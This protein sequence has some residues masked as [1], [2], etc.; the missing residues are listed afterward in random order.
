MGKSQKNYMS[1]KSKLMAAVAMLLVASFMVV[2]STYA[3]FTLSTAPEVTGIKTSVGANGNLEIALLYDA[4]AATAADL[5]NSLE[6]AAGKITTTTGGL[7]DLAEKNKTWGNLVS[8]MEGENDLYGLNQISLKPTRLNV[9]STDDG[10]SFTLAAAPLV[11]PEYGADG[12]ITNL[13]PNTESGVYNNGNYTS[14]G[15]GVRAIGSISGKAQQEID[16][17]NAMQEFNIAIGQVSS[18]AAKS[19]N[20]NGENLTTLI[21]KYSKGE[22]TL[23]AT[24][25]VNMLNALNGTNNNNKGVVYYMTEAR[26]AL[27]KAAYAYLNETAA[28]DEYISVTSVEIDE[29]DTITLKNGSTELGKL[30]SDQLASIPNY[31]EYV[32]YAKNVAAQISDANTAAGTIVDPENTDKDT[33]ED[34][35]GALMNPSKMKVQG[36][37]TSELKDGM[38]DKDLLVYGQELMAGAD[39]LDVE[40]FAGSGVYSD[41]AQAT[42]AEIKGSATFIVI[43]VSIRT[44]VTEEFVEGDE[45]V[46]SFFKP[47]VPD[48]EVAETNKST[49]FTDLYGYALD[50]AFRTN[51]ANSNLLLQS[52]AANRIYS[53]NGSAETMGSGA[54]MTFSSADSA[55]VAANIK[56][57]MEN[58]NVVFVDVDGTIVAVAKADTTNTEDSADGKVTAK[59]YLHE[60][61]F[62]TA[63]VDEKTVYTDI[64]VGQKKG[65]EENG[66][67]DYNPVIMSLDQNKTTVLSAY[68]YLDGDTVE[69][70]DVATGAE[71]MSGTI[72]LQFSSDAELKPMQYA[73]LMNGSSSSTDTETPDAGT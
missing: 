8:M 5:S 52:E 31:T 2:S 9:I 64:K 32:A 12:R 63:T 11:T 6:T 28:A 27:I 61:T 68:V 71:S 29:N 35:L 51:A 67:G 46:E 19:I 54:T 16:H 60:F 24:A 62:N 56:E 1:I 49:N 14:K 53:E 66:T 39:K 69:N 44:N 40:M 50:L 23:D 48:P 55:F 58:I 33:V 47:N 30:S 45:T 43:P 26:K 25:L 13:T 10:E 72:N 18:I 38:G 57:L 17:M 37:T 42:G 59:L 65:L 20:E 36:K 70:S 73:D 4:N 3:W 22:E 7:T 41:I 15:I 34:I 21:L